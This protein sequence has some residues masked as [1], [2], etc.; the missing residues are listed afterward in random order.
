MSRPTDRNRDRS[1]DNQ[2]S[3][4]EDGPKSAGP[5]PRRGGLRY[6]LFERLRDYF[7]AGLLTT[8]PVMATVWLLWELIGFVDAKVTPYI[9]LKWNPETY[10]P[11]GL[12]GFGLLALSVLLTLI[13]FLTTGYF[14]RV[15]RYGSEVIMSRLPVV[16]S[17]HGPINQIFETVFSQKSSAFRE[18]VLVEY[19]KRG[20][21]AVGFITGKTKGE[22]QH[23]TSDAVLNVFVPATPNP[24]SGFLLFVP[25]QDV[26]HLD[27]TVE[28]G[29]KLVISGG[30]IT[31][32]V[33][34][35]L[36][37]MQQQETKEGRRDRSRQK[38]NERS[39][40]ERQKMLAKRGL[41][42][43]LRNY[44]LAGLLITA[45]TCLSLWLVW[46]VA[47]FTDDLV[48]E[49][50]SYFWQGAA[51]FSL[52]VPG[53]GLVFITI[54]LT[55]IGFFAAGFIGRSLVLVGERALDQM[56]VIR[57]L[58]STLKQLIETIFNQGS[59][60]FSKVVLVQYPREE[61]WALGFYTGESH[62]DIRYISEEESINVFLP[63]TPNPTSGFLL[64]VPKR[65]AVFLD[66]TVEQGIKMVV[67]GG[68]VT[69]D[70]T[71]TKTNVVK[72]DSA[73]C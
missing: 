25:V 69:P 72:A 55:L 47:V 20:C 57:T 3:R 33:L 12:P 64:F 61:S 71:T 49:Y 13:G 45:P 42:A 22:V 28:E 21:W 19:P 32:Q 1:L 15:I 60:A 52:F 4:V 26:Y 50:V 41:V 54:L 58:Y 16:R 17:L 5:E 2:N 65:Q 51:R 73:A 24:T 7:V 68:I 40:E 9:P 36:Q 43:R 27:V 8:T 31:P 48:V 30:I 39:Q 38:R 35:K 29:I 6:R 11:F 70:Y 66:M 56:P 46:K 63:T 23:C 59:T 62:E 53:F 14:G 34:R 44:F 18:V 37:E 10:L 67:S